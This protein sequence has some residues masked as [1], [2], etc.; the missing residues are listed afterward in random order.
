MPAKHCVALLS[1]IQ[2]K[3]RLR[4]R[5]PNT[6]ATMESK[7]L[8]GGEQYKFDVTE[9]RLPYIRKYATFFPFLFQKRVVWLLSNDM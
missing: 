3:I 1:K 2:L 7:A 5:F 4:G 6:L 8:H 9:R